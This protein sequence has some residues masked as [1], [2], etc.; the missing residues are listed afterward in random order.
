[1][2]QNM[3][4]PKFLAAFGVKR[5]IYI[6]IGLLIACIVFLGFLQSY[7]APILIG[8]IEL[9][10]IVHIHAIVFIGWV[11]LFIAQTL[12]ASTGHLALHRMLG[13]IHFNKITFSKH[14]V[15]VV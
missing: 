6:G 2:A 5:F 10:P 3:L 15:K 11:A 14:C 8:S 7:F 13:K 4:I 1:M 12:F 9:K